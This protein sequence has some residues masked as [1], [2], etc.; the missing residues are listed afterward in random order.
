ML[1]HSYCFNEKTFSRLL[2]H[3]I[4]LCLNAR[5]VFQN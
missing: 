5:N 2:Y 4:Y 3:Y 1:H